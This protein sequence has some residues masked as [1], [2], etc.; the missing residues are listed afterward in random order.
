MKKC[1]WRVLTMVVAIL[2]IATMLGGCNN[3]PIEDYFI[4][5]ENATILVKVEYG[6]STWLGYSKAGGFIDD[7]IY[8]K[9]KKNEYQEG[10]IEIYH[11]YKQGSSIVVNAEEIACIQT[12]TYKEF[13]NQYPPM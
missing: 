2:V 1:V 5:Y 12:K 11:P 13:Y 9:Y 7:D 10:K 3:T 6:D 4:K 8:E